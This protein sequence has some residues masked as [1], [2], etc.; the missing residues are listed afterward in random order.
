MSGFSKKFKRQRSLEKQQVIRQHGQVVG[1]IKECKKGRHISAHRKN[2]RN[3]YTCL[4][5]ERIQ[6]ERERAEFANRMDSSSQPDNGA[7]A[8]SA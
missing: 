8:E 7:E 5:C 6:I 2:S 1:L 4:T 3:S